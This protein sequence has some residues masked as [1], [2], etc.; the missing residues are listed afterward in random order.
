MNNV[1]RIGAAAVV[2]LLSGL[3]MVG[4]EGLGNTSS[5]TSDVTGSW[6]FAD[7]AGTQ[8]TWALVQSSDGALS[9]AGTLGETITG[10]VS[11]DMIYMTLR[12]STSSNTV[13]SGT[14]DGATMSGQYTNSVTGGGSW[15]AVKTN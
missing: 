3:A 15:T 7:T 4:C 9:G 14:V 8:S 5:A 13:L 6:S 10:S 1:T 11:G 2:S 12:Y